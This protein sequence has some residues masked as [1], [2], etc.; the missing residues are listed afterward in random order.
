MIAG[1]LL[2][3]RQLYAFLKTLGHKPTKEVFEGESGDYRFW[4]T[5]GESTF[6]FP[7]ATLPALTSF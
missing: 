7:T 1:I 5:P 6:R 4:V 2:S 3:K